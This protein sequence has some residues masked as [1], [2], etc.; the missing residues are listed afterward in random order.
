MFVGHIA[1]GLA[2]KRAV[3]K[4]SLGALV[5]APAFL[6]ILWPV[7]LLLGWESVRIDPG[8]TA[9]T[10]LAFDSYPISH[11]LVTSLGWGVLF[12][13]VSGWMTRSSKIGA[14]AGLLV[15]SHWVLDW[16]THRP[17]LPLVPG[18]AT[19]GLGLWG[20]VPATLVIET[21]MFGAGLF[22]YAR[23][24]HARDGIGTWALV[25]FALLLYAIYVSGP[26]GPPPPSVRVLE[27]MALACWLLPLW[28]WW[29]DRHRDPT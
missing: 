15:V 22:V 18:G 17:D 9:F 26:F 28:A 25:A 3:P 24:T 2:A 16:I 6:D 13:L 4:A 27:M 11:S 12:G 8:N 7:F 5:A 10:P 29:I 19:Y 23:A 20:S 14:L 21:L 1:L